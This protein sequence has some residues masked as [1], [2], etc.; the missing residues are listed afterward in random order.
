MRRAG[1]RVLGFG[2]ESFSPA[3]LEEFNKSQIYRHIDAVHCRPR[4]PM[5][6]TPF[7][8][9][10]LCSPRARLADVAETIRQAYRWVLRGC[11]IGMYPYVVPFTGSKMSNDPELAPHVTSTLPRDRRHR[12][13]VATAEAHP[14]DRP[15]GSARDGGDRR[16]LRGVVGDADGIVPS[17]SVARSL[18]AL[19]RGRD[20]R[21]A[22]SRAR[23]AGQRAGVAQG[24]R[25]R[26]IGAPTR[27]GAT[28]RTR[29]RQ[30]VALADDVAKARQA[31][32][33][34]RARARVRGFALPLLAHR[35]NSTSACISSRRRW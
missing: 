13:L 20:S 19:D 17:R 21:A 26:C 32:P 33:R 9:L 3:M 30:P 15:R 16:G 2:I 34:H 8:D 18:A 11:E 31:D 14:A 12:R 4:S 6:L 29:P 5:G 27:Q 10:I 22:Q 7:L 23:D 1:F 35:P 25:I 24:A 28:S